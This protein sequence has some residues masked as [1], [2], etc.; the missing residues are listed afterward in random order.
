MDTLG[1]A[2]SW[3]DLD[4]PAAQLSLRINDQCPD[5]LPDVQ[6]HTFRV[7]PVLVLLGHPP[8]YP[9]GHLTAIFEFISDHLRA[10]P[11]L[12]TKTSRSSYELG[13]SKP[14]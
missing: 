2:P 5:I 10:R 13:L 7:D 14:S 8:W 1:R 9:F 3:A 6:H 4:F 12:N 11:R